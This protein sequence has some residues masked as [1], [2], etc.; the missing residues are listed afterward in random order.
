MTVSDN[1]ASQGSM[2]RKRVLI[3]GGAGFVGRTLCRLIYDNQDVCVVDTLNFGPD[4]FEPAELGKFRL[5]T[6][7]IRD[8]DALTALVDDFKPDVIVH[9][10]AIHFIPAC[11]G[12][13]GNASSINVVGTVNLLSVCPADC[14][15]VFASTGA[16]YAPSDA[17]HDEVTSEIG[18]RDAYG[19]NKL[20][21]ED[22]VRYFAGTKNLAAVIVRLF[23]VAGPGETN[24][25]LLPEIVAQM[26]A[27]RNS[28]KLGNLWPKRDYIHVRDAASGFAAAG[29]N[30]TVAQGE[31]VTVNLGT[32]KQYSVNE[33]IERLRLLS[34]VEFAVEADAS[35]VRAVDRPFLGAAIDRIGEKFSWT[36]Q[37]DINDALSDLWSNPDFTRELATKY[38]LDG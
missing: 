28:V 21:G 14:R 15:F 34:G 12:Q 31:V 38:D 23:N 35:R 18:P 11:E 36:P 4:R 2:L 1:F 30:G 5:E 8:L 13:P 22:Y 26:K 25:H 33:I 7:D 9:L 37:F 24:P 3:S 10:A 17:L 29:L 20:H 6:I 16:V 27:G 19:F 32:S